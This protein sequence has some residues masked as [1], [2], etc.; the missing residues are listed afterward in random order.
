ME[1]RSPASRALEV[2]A[3]AGQHLRDWDMKVAVLDLG[4]LFAK[5]FKTSTAPPAVPSPAAASSRSGGA[6]TGRRAGSSAGASL[7]AAPTPAPSPARAPDSPSASRGPPASLHPA[8]AASYPG[9][10]GASR[11]VEA[12][13][14]PLSLPS[15]PRA[16]GVQPP[17]LAPAG[18]GRSAAGSPAPLVT[19]ARPCAG[20]GGVCAALRSGGGAAGG[21][22][23][24]A[25]PRSTRQS[26]PGEREP[27]A[28][29][30]AGP[31]PKT[32]FLALPDIGEECASD[33]D[34]EDGGE[35]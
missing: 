35:A 15:S 21:S 31:G 20:A 28:W 6:A 8:L 5:I 17:P 25:S 2:Q 33:S 26:G 12:V 13:G 34:S 19:S 3:A 4:S 7:S 27:G 30:P 22:S 29:I 11:A 24:A 1:P 16:A 18:S 23:L 14:T 9:V 32:L 10:S